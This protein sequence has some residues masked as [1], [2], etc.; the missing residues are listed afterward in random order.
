M[1]YYALLRLLHPKVVL[2]EVEVS[3]RV[4]VER[5]VNQVYWMA[6]RVMRRLFLG[7]FALRRVVHHRQRLAGAGDRP[8]PRLDAPSGE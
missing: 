6:Q 4:V 1:C 8:G 3:M 5:E 2:L 7:H